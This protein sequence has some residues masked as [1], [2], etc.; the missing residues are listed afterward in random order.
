MQASFA[1]SDR[2]SNFDGYADCVPQDDF[3]FLAET[4][5]QTFASDACTV[6]AIFLSP[7]ALIRMS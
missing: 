7:K 2:N 4:L 1:S 3:K 5:T 6:V